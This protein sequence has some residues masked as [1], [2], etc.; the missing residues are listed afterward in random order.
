MVE[1]RFIKEILK[2][3]KKASLAGEVP[4]GAIV[5]DS[6]GRI[7]GR[8][9]NKTNASKDGLMHAE[10]LAIRQAEKKLGDW[11]LEGCELYVTLE[12][13][14]MCL[15]AIGNTRISRAHYILADPLFGSLASKLSPAQVAKLYPNLKAV[16]IPDEEEVKTLMSDFFR[17]LRAKAKRVRMGQSN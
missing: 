1:S 9:A 7:I 11:R 2:L 12:P 10:M 13:C 3:A 6:M 4:V 17:D 15:G 16:K 5:V 8:G 14:L